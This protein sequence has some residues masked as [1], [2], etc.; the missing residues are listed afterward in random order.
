MDNT[1]K[2]VSSMSISN[3]ISILK[4]YFKTI[5]RP[6]KLAVESTYNWYFF[7]DLAEEFAEEVFLANPYELKA[8][9]KRN[10]NR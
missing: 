5:P 6:F 8:F 10:K 3:E 1:G 2:R 9:A 7:V 4:Q